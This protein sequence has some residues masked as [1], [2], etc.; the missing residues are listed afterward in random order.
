MS[1]ETPTERY[2]AAGDAPTR[3]L[4][5]GNAVDAPELEEQRRSRR[6]FVILGVVGGLLLLA[7]VVLLILLLIRPGDPAAAPTSTPSPTATTASPTPSASPT[8]TPTQTEA[9]APPAPPPP[10]ATGAIQS[11]DVDQTS[12][13]CSGGGSV[14]VQFSWVAEGETLW[15]GVGTDNAKNAP[16]DTYPLVYTL[17]FDY[18][19]GNGQ[20]IYTITV[21]QSTGELDSETIT[22]TEQ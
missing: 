9:P 8:P 12:V 14:P 21:E 5:T 4:D 20:Q 3:R 17:D 1:D 19:C 15:F 6:L 10:P 13:D 7:I 16:Y 2:D 18:Q 22:I 11:F